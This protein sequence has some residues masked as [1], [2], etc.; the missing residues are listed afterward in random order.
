MSVGYGWML[1]IFYF[2]TCVS[3][4]RKY[5][6]YAISVVAIINA[7]ADCT[8]GL[9]IAFLLTL[10]T[11]GSSITKNNMQ[12]SYNIYELFAKPILINTFSFLQ[13]VMF[14]FNFYFLWHK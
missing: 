1:A 7:A 6:I 3:N 9:Y 8:L 10:N 11:G 4:Q 2:F 13:S 5:R 12:G 14:R